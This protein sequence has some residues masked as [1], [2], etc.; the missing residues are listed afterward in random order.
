MEGK[1]YFVRER[2]NLDFGSLLQRE[3]ASVSFP[4]LLMWREVVG[5]RFT[6]LEKSLQKYKESHY[7]QKKERLLMMAVS[8]KVAGGAHTGMRE[9]SDLMKNRMEADEFKRGIDFFEG[10]LTCTSMTLEDDRFYGSPKSLP[11]V[12]EEIYQP[13][14]TSDK[15]GNAPEIG[16]RFKNKSLTKEGRPKKKYV[17]LVH[18]LEAYHMRVL[19]FKHFFMQNLGD[20][21]YVFHAT[22]CN[23]NKTMDNINHL[24]ANLIHD[25][26]TLIQED[27]RNSAIESIS[28]V[29][30]SMGGLIIRAALPLLSGYKSLLKTF[31]TFATPHLGVSSPDSTM[32]GVGR[33]G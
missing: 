31:I 10:L 1:D 12:Y 18:G 19:I 27:F 6:N 5:S 30:H 32:M 21:D 9:D 7:K 24:A 14:K 20:P 13:A 26:E 29:G 33:I 25:I 2:N 16:K 23:E 28:F 11:F 22:E 8:H 4:I 3:V 17:F 15:S